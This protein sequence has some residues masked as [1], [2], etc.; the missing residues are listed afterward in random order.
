M[1]ATGQPLSALRRALVKFP[2]LASALTVREKKPLESLPT[3]PAVIKAVETELGAAGRV[4]VRY[5]GTEPKLRL[6]VEGPTDVVVRAA[7]A[8]L[9]AAVRADLEVV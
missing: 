1:L 4:L 5:S 2:Q 8:K 7:L 3:L 6:L 9:E